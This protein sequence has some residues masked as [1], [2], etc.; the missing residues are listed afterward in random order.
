M[1]AV[2]FQSSS[3]TL[4]R[5]TKLFTLSAG[6]A[7]RQF[8]LCGS[9]AAASE[10][11]LDFSAFSSLLDGICAGLGCRMGW[12][13]EDSGHCPVLFCQATPQ[14][15]LTGWCDLG[16]PAQAM[17]AGFKGMLGG[18]ISQWQSGVTIVWGAVPHQSPACVCAWLG[19][20]I[21]LLPSTITIITL[22]RTSICAFSLWQVFLQLSL[23]YNEI[24]FE[25]YKEN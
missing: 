15:S 21:P 3:P 4:Q 6:W 25:S 16:N 23:V 8:V 17:V 5:S 24:C 10:M 18:D 11:V 12:G 22:L 14:N 20:A 2:C 19:C 7:L 1:V 13:C 9:G